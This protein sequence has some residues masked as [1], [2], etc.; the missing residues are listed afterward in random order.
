M[1][2]ITGVVCIAIFSS[3]ASIAMAGDFYVYPAKK[4]T[5][6]QQNKDMQECL[7]WAKQQTGFDPTAAPTNVAPPQSQKTHRGGALR[8]AAGGAVLG[9]IINDDAG[10]GAAV[11]ATL[12]AVRGSRNRRNAAA[13][14]QASQAQSEA[15][16]N[17]QRTSYNN[18]YSA[19]LKGRDYSLSPK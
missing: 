1:K 7:Q 14:Q 16:Y 11:G 3:V 9:E 17:Q 6:E 2:Q 4:Q 19:C 15:Q 12:G 13:E 18:A 5:Q 8:G 10:K